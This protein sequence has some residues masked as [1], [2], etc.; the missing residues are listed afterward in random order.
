MKGQPFDQNLGCEP[1]P[2]TALS[3][4]SNAHQPLTYAATPYTATVSP[5]PISEFNEIPN[6]P[7]P[8]DASWYM[9]PQSDSMPSS[10]LVRNATAANRASA[11]P[12]GTVN[13]ND[14]NIHRSN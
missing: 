14:I 9:H 12:P 10:G 6:Y 7:V 13:P 2:S 8:Q 4:Q 5:L 11:A 1:S 3:R